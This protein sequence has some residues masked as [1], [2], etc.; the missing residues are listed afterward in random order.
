LRGVPDLSDSDSSVDPASSESGASNLSHNDTSSPAEVKCQASEALVEGNETSSHVA[1]L[2]AV[3]SENA[4]ASDNHDSALVFDKQQDLHQNLQDMKLI[5]RISMVGH[6]A[7][8][9]RLAS[10]HFQRLLISLQ[11][12]TSL[13][14]ILCAALGYLSFPTTAAGNILKTYPASAANDILVLS[15][16]AS[17][18]LSYPGMSP[19]FT[20]VILANLLVHLSAVIVFPCRQSV[21][22]LLF[23]K[24]VLANECSNCL[25]CPSH[26]F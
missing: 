9:W 3:K 7:A 2:Q 10:H 19:R 22:R 18:I 15:M 16:A 6:A 25:F 24:K 17:I 26:V 1:E 4:A 13:S 14:Y 11:A 20:Y 23:P 5:V 12:V 21:D 8:A